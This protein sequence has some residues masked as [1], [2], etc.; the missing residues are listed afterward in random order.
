[1]TV[2]RHVI[3][4]TEQGTSRGDTGGR[5]GS[6]SSA[7]MYYNCVSKGH[8]S[9]IERF[10]VITRRLTGRMRAAGY[11]HNLPLETDHQSRK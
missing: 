7:I 6:L 5:H 4:A 9:T 11:K 10:Q 2:L 8:C 1:V 3:L